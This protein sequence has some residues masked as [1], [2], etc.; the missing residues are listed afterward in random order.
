M[1]V[2][3]YVYG[4]RGDVDQ[5]IQ[6]KCLRRLGNS[7]KDKGIRGTLTIQRITIIE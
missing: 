6:S 2:C 5:F 7:H 3:V 4:E 1:I